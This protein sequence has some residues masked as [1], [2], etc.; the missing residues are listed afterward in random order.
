MDE[1]YIDPILQELQTQQPVSQIS[2]REALEDNPDAL[3]ILLRSG[4]RVEAIELYQRQNGGSW[5]AALDAIKDLE[6]KLAE[7]GAV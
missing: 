2:T 6:R 3:R 4:N 5:R 1:G 7:E